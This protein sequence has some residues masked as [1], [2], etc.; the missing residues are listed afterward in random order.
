[1]HI[2]AVASYG[3]TAIAIQTVCGRFDFYFKRVI[4]ACLTPKSVTRR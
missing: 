3:M 2:F 1:L 4:F